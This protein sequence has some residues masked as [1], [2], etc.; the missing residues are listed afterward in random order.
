MP[1][2]S[3]PDTG[4]E[5]EFWE[6]Q[7]AISGRTRRR[8]DPPAGPRAD[9]RV[10]DRG[11]RSSSA[12]P[13]GCARALADR[14]RDWRGDPRFGVVVLVLVAVVAGVVWYRIGIGGGTD[15]AGAAPSAV[16]HTATCDSSTA[17]TSAPNGAG[18]GK[19]AAA[20][21]R[22]SCTWPAR[23]R[24]QEWSSSVRT[25]ASSTRSR[26]SA[27][28][29]ADADLDRLNLAAKLADGERV[30]VA[31]VGQADPGVA[32]P[33]A[34]RGR[35]RRGHRR[36]A[37]APR[38]TSTPPRRRSSR[39]CPAS[40][41]PTRR[42]SSPSG[43]GVAASRRSTSCAACGASATSDSPSSRRSSPCDRAAAPCGAARDARGGRRRHRARRGR[44][45][46][47]RHVAARRRVSAGW[48]PRRRACTRRA[49]RVAIAVVSFALLGTAAMQR[50]PRRARRTRRSPRWS[51]DAGRRSWCAAR[52]ST[53]PT[54]VGWTRACSCA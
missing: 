53:T 12:S 21:R 43:S 44:R 41:P 6:N 3:P 24:I 32:A 39:R 4:I 52:W 49:H 34:R 7:A 38:S 36:G 45:A 19:P 46:G 54:A 1:S 42:R 14:V 18:T 23:S 50:A 27:A 51:R 40:G 30:F 31:K 2:L 26:R 5:Q 17:T 8:A 20:P 33:A 13:T 16:T 37:R 48:R 28:R 29:Y 9:A 35:R 15:A 22:S 47:R 11:P 10:P 25:P